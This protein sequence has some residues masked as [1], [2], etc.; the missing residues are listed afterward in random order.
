MVRPQGW[1]CEY[2]YDPFGR[3]LWKDVGSVRTYYQY[4]DEGLIGE[5]DASGNEIKIYGWAP[6]SLWGADPIF[7]KV[8]GTYYWYQNNHHGT[9]QKLI[10]TSGAV[11]WE[12]VY[13][14]FGNVQIVA[15]EITNNLRFAGQYYDQETGLHYNWY[16]YY[17]PTAG[18]YLQ[19]DPLGD[20]LNLYAYCFN[21]PHTWIDPSGLCAV[22]NVWNW[23]KEAWDW[24]MEQERRYQ[25]ER[26]KEWYDFCKEFGFLDENGNPLPRDKVFKRGEIPIG[27]G[28]SLRSFQAAKNLPRTAKNLPR[29]LGKVKSFFS[30]SNKY[31]PK[32]GPRLPPRGTKAR[33]AIEKARRQGIQAK[34][35]QEL[36]DIRS[37]GKGSGIYSKGELEQIRKTGQF[38][39]DVR[40]HHDPTVANRPDLAA[41]PNAVRPV[42]GGT[43]GHLDAHGGD[44]RLP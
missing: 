28:G 31:V 27:P 7:L 41:N 14:S 43:P 12:A 4:A 32:K 19:T 9:P 23:T 5:Y 36:A 24:I 16:R 10:A 37:G 2:Y 17:D 21:N 3:R 42:R 25:A 22:N 26:D 13:E 34:K 20:G 8:E 11:V 33:A 6:D 30:R 18:R 15:E 38:P 40:W 44:W 29:A 1:P 39:S 35:A